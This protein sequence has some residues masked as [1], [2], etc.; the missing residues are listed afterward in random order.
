[1]SVDVMSAVWKQSKAT[2]TA[3]LLL[4]A[5]ADN[6]NSEGK[7]YPSVKR[8]AQK[9]RTSERNVQ[10]LLRRL[11]ELGELA[12]E[13]QAE[14]RGCNAY[15][16]LLGANGGEEDFTPAPKQPAPRGEEDFTRGGEEDF[17]GGVKV[18]S[19]G[20]VKRISPEPSVEPSIQPSL[21]EGAREAPPP[22][23][24]P[25][26]QGASKVVQSRSPH[27]PKGLQLP[28]GYV[29]AGSAQNAV[30]VYYER[31]RYDDPA[32]RLS[33]PQED[34]LVRICTD[35]SRLRE[36][37][38]AYSRTN[39]RPGNV[40]LI[41][42]WYASGVP[43]RVQGVTHGPTTHNGTAQRGHAAGGGQARQPWAN[44]QPQPSLDAVSDADF[45]ASR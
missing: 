14:K 19:P 38:T 4:L 31:F 39:Y 44:Y 26:Q 11:E 22:P 12:I 18:A 34:D 13:L 42:D 16:V 2:G 15:Y 37:V 9:I 27:M 45:W 29:P 6:A 30:Q 41:L 3:L 1:M 5:I 24:L 23:A 7:A 43:A 32:A 8:L 21:V 40:Q 20:G 36:A 25:P 28:K 35:L 33:A 10:L 17:T